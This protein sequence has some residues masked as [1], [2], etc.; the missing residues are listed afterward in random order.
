VS[1]VGDLAYPIKLDD[2][3]PTHGE[4]ANGHA[5][6]FDERL[7]EGMAVGPV[8]D[9][10]VFPTGEVIR[11]ADGLRAVAECSAEPSGGGER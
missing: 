6:F 4:D 7:T 11:K 8:I 10:E 2:E 3:I 9:D 1:V 5:V